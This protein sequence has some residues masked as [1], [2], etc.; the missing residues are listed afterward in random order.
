MTFLKLLL[1]LPGANELTDNEEYMDD[2]HQ[3]P[4]TTKHKQYI[5]FQTHCIK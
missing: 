2:I 4:P 3:Y 5:I 1:Y